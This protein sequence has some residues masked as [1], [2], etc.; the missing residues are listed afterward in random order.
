M[1]L[2]LKILLMRRSRD[3][4]RRSTKGDRGFA[5]PIV[6]ALGLIMVVLSIASIYKSSDQ[7]ISAT[8]QRGTSKA[9]AAAEAGVAYYMAFLNRN[10]AIASYSYDNWT[11]AS[12]T[13]AGLNTCDTFV[14]IENW[15]DDWRSAGTDG[16][17]Q[18]ISYSYLSAGGV[19][20][21][22]GTVPNNDTYG[23]LT[24][25]GTGSFSGNSFASTRVKV[26][27]PVRQE[28]IGSSYP[29]VISPFASYAL[30]PVLWIRSY[31]NTTNLGNLQVASY[32]GQ[33]ANFPYGGNIVLSGLPIACQLP[34]TGVTTANLEDPSRQYII[35][36]TRDMPGVA[37]LPTPPLVTGSNSYESVTNADLINQTLPINRLSPMDTGFKNATFSYGGSPH[38]YYSYSGGALTLNSNQS[39]SSQN[40]SKVVLFLNDN[41]TING[42]AGINSTTTISSPYLEI[43]G[44]SGTTSIN[45]VGPGTINIKGFIHAPNATVNVTGNPTLNITGA[46]WVRNWVDSAATGAAAGSRIF[47][48]LA[49]HNGFS[50]QST[51]GF[52][53]SSYVT[54]KPVISSP[55]KWETL[56][57]N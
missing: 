22:A 48:D 11:N 43:Y 39:F 2:L 33:A 40:M 13:A 51:I 47:P 12:F 1:N 10:S 14:N 44:L 37:V 50:H 18:L 56:E 41:L 6:I 5:I 17:Y 25:L 27:I 42:N 30:N 34:T 7:N 35:A 52:T 19:V 53:T 29:G 55:I 16:S 46:M 20:P 8:T 31:D 23:E 3:G 24:V 4:N 57:A 15:K 21:P 54:S 9:L 36:D 38:Y 28:N 45:L 32:Q 49:N 26:Q